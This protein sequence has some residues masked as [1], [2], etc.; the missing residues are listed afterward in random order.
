MKD[1][2]STDFLVPLTAVTMFALGFF[3]YITVWKSRKIYHY[4]RSVFSRRQAVILHTVIQK[5]SMLIVFGL[6]PAIVIK[7]FLHMN[8]MDFGFRGFALKNSTRSF[9]LLMAGIG[10]GCYMNPGAG[11]KNWPYPQMRV[12]IWTF[13]LF[14]L[15]T[16]LWAVFLLAY[17]FMFRGFLFYAFLPYG[18]GISVLINVS[19]YSVTHIWKGLF[20]ALGT[21]PLGIILCFLTFES[22]TI[23]PAFF[24]HYVMAVVTNIAS[25]RKKSGLVFIRSGSSK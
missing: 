20:E 13:K 22:E 2:V 4:L 9:L 14:L 6:F 16:F 18:F 3:I 10:I 24:L 15:N 11:Q 19:L 25:I 8:L 7:Y 5:L 21:I 17:E 12:K 1:G 23:L